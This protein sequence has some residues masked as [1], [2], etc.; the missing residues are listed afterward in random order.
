VCACVCVSLVLTG[1]KT[2]AVVL[3]TTSSGEYHYLLQ[4]CVCVCVY[5]VS[6]YLAAG[7][8]SVLLG[9]CA[10]IFTA[11]NSSQFTCLITMSTYKICL[12]HDQH[13]F[14]ITSIYAYLYVLNRCCRALLELMLVPQFCG[15]KCCNNTIIFIQ[16]PGLLC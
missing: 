12:A 9:I 10:V 16:V 15:K 13:K 4:W 3:S 14:G 11:W 2:L 6:A 8:V 1:E 5:L 7:L